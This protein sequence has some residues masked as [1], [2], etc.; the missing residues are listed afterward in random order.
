MHL[1][2]ALR[3]EPQW[4]NLQ[5]SLRPHSWWGVG[6]LPLFQEPL[7]CYRPSALRSPPKT[8]SHI[9]IYMLFICY[10]LSTILVNKDYQIPVYAYEI[11]LPILLFGSTC[12][13]IAARQQHSNV[14]L[15]SA[16][17]VVV[18]RRILKR[19]PIVSNELLMFFI[20]SSQN[21]GTV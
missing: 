2:L 18:T 20:P 9:H 19:V 11:H 10:L 16:D 5:C 1:P 15:S 13:I 12:L 6:S 7:L 14:S 8:N 21:K 3:P 4:E 17:A